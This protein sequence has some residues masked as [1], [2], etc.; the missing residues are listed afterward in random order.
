MQHFSHAT[1]PCQQEILHIFNKYN[2]LYW[3]PK[4]GQYM[5]RKYPTAYYLSKKYEGTETAGIK[6]PG[7]NSMRTFSRFGNPLK[8]NSAIEAQNN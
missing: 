8:A 2:R 4:S 3:P 5:A 7:I 6:N 1:P